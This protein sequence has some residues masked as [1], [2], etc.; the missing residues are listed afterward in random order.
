MSTI[1][2]ENASKV[3]GSRTRK[4]VVTVA[5]KN[6]NV[7]RVNLA[8]AHYLYVTSTLF[9]FVSS[10]VWKEEHFCL[11]SDTLE[12]LLL[13]VQNCGTRYLSVGQTLLSLVQTEQRQTIDYFCISD[14]LRTHVLAQLHRD[15]AKSRFSQ[16]CRVLLMSTKF[17][18]SRVAA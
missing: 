7:S 4:S 12:V 9:C 14:S 5:F 15:I 3:I 6:Y 11:S 17:D 10:C 13:T 2:V 8:L 18:K 16:G 1:A